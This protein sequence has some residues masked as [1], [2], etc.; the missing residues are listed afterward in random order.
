MQG[1][2]SP[3]RRRGLPLW[4]FAVIAA[5]GAASP[6]QAR[7]KRPTPSAAAEADGYLAAE[8]R[9]LAQQ[10]A[11]RGG[12]AAGVVDLM[13]LQALAPWR[14]EGEITADLRAA[15]EDPERAPLVQAAAWWLLRELALERMDME[16]ARAAQGALGLIT[17]F[18]VR[19][20]EAPDPLADV[21]PA[22]WRIYPAQ[23]GTGEVWLDAAVRPLGD[24][25]ATLI[26]EIEAPAGAPMGAILRLG[27]DDQVTV[28]L[29]GDEIYK[30]PEPHRAWLDQAAVPL[31]LKPGRNRLM[32]QVDQREGA[33]RLIARITDAEGR[34]LPGIQA[35][36]DVTGPPPAPLIEPQPP[37][38]YADVW[39]DLWA[40][41]EQDAPP[42]Q[43]LRDVAEYARVTGMP[44][45]DQTEP[46]VAVEAA[47]E[48]DPSPRS[49]RAWVRLLPESRQQ[50]IRAAHVPARPILLADVVAEMFDRLDVAWGHY[51]ARRHRAALALIEG[52]L[53][54]DERFAPAWRLK[55]VILE[56][57][58]L[59]NA[60]AQVLEAGAARC[61]PVPGLRK[62]HASSLKAAGRHE[63]ALNALQAL[64]RDGVAGAGERFRLA[65]ILHLRG[66]GAAAVALLDAV[67]EARPELWYHALEAAQIQLIQGDRADALARLQILDARMPDASPVVELLAEAHARLGDEEAARLQLA[68]ALKLDAGNELLERRL[69]ALSARGGPEPLGPALD[70]ILTTADPQGASAHVLYH[71][72]RTEVQPTGLAKRRLR[73][74]VR[75]LD[76]EGARQ[77]ASW[78][79]PYVPGRQRL[80]IE[81]ARL[82][83]R[84]QPPSSPARSDRD[85]SEPEY[86]LYYDLRAEV[87]TFDQPQPGDVIEVSWSLT[88][89][90]G[91]PAFPGYYGELAYVQEY[92]PRAR[93]V[94][95]ITGPA[96]DELSVQLADRGVQVSQDTLEGGGRRFTALA[97][98][99]VPWEPGMPSGST[100][101][102]FVHMSTAKDWAEIDRRYRDLL[103]DR[104][105]P[106]RALKALAAEW[107]AGAEGAKAQISRLYAEVA[108]RT[109]YVGLEL[110]LHSFQ[111]EQPRVTL[112][113]GY[114]DCKDKATLLIALARALGHEAH[115]TLVRTRGSGLIPPKPASLAVFDHAI[116]YVPALDAFLDPTV[117]RNDPWVLPPSD[118]GAVAFV[119]GEDE[120]PRQIPVQSADVNQTDW[121]MTLTLD[122]Q[123]AARGRWRWITR[124]HPGTVARRALEGAGGRAEIVARALGERFP[125][126]H[127][128]D[129]EVEG[130][131]PALD[132]VQAEGRLSL[133]LSRAGRGVEIPLGGG[134]WG[135]V[136]SY[137]EAA[138]RA[139]PLALTFKHTW[140]QRLEIRLPSGWSAKAVA[141]VVLESP[142]GRFEAKAEVSPGQITLDAALRLD[143][144]DVPPDRYPAF[145]A[146]LGQIDEALAR[147]VEVG[148]A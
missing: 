88:D 28:W 62:A 133:P 38:V 32:F 141:P 1:G 26:T 105:I 142:F 138:R 44:N 108:A 126:V 30:A 61:G 116:V 125:G 14:P 119:V 23:M 136:S 128:L 47:W 55:A 111:P 12:E 81:S 34:P 58:G 101:R 54:R 87:L 29:N 73:R 83:R 3:D 70:E 63:E 64:I 112:A 109:R 40:V 118:Q 147:T 39:R 52:L 74:V 76:A 148:G 57:I 96:A 42:A 72:A 2:L 69:E 16:T 139:T 37:E 71:H 31:V 78:S 18:R 121:Q 98:P 129:V 143:V 4:I 41:T 53:A 43:G 117:D 21:D 102:A 10:A 79:L 134:P 94:V 97:V 80:E 56:D 90:E 114:G 11:R 60:G 5:C 50:T 75:L 19:A 7:P 100:L 131:K 22:S 99:A 145:R 86:R 77:F 146:W 120:A 9:R 144:R 35:S 17:A 20:G 122:R 15:A 82:I 84:G 91:D 49:L 85:L 93:S 33:W 67:T 68:R 137:A 27:F 127:I 123:G 25:A 48:D 6:A 104:H 132:P 103:S 46:Q 8:Q 65:Q 89:L 140:R 95:E 106:D 110:G 13:R 24:T 92:F 130:V 113:R 135:L 107:A 45:H 66:E 115:L 36:A 124:G 51:Y 59:P